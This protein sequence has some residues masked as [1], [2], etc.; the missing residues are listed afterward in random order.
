VLSLNGEWR[1]ALARNAA[2]AEGL[3]RFHEPSF[4]PRAFRPLP[5][6]A[7]WAMHGFEEPFYAQT[8]RISGRAILPEPSEAEGFYL[9]R[10]AVP[11]GAAGRRAVLRFDGV[12][13]SAEVWLNGRPLGRH[14]SGFT[15]FQFDVADRLLPGAENTLAVRVRQRTKDSMLD[16]NDDW[17]LGG[18][19]RDVSLE[20]MPA[21]SFIERVEVATEFDERFRDA[22]LNLRV[23]VGRTADH[24][25]NPSRP[26]SP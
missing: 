3:A 13:S 23:F 14:D 10:F 4:D 17:V 24:T 16:T 15:G 2:E 1:F 6:P 11:A 8:Y 18:I 7:N 12:W 26:G 9:H 21:E 19:Y 20:L 5:V 25:P 22:N